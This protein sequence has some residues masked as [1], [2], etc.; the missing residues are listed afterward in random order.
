[1]CAYKFITEQLAER[2]QPLDQIV[3]SGGSAGGHLSL[4]VGLL[5]SRGDH[6]CRAA[7]PPRAVVNWFGI[8]D[9][10]A[11]DEYLNI[12]IMPEGAPS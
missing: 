1:M 6:P 4:T 9:I 11:V 2:G 3:V 5:N 7:T 8:T 10:E 12:L